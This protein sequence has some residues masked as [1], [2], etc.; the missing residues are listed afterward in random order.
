MPSKVN[1]KFSGDSASA[2]GFAGSA[3]AYYYWNTGLLATVIDILAAR[4]VLVRL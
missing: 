1:M 2:Q 3:S 4:F